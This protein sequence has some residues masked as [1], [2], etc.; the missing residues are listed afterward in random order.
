MI[1]PSKH[2]SQSRA[3]VGIGAEILSQLEEPLAVSELWE[4]VRATRGDKPDE[5]PLSFD[6]FVLALTFLHAIFAVELS[7]GIITMSRRSRA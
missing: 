5:A 7:D 4:R 2:L 3:L 1:L 6:W